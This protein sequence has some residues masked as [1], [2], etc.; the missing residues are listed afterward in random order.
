MRPGSSRT[1]D[2]EKESNKPEAPE[3]GRRNK[4]KTQRSQSESDYGHRKHKN[5]KRPTW[6][7]SGAVLEEHK[8]IKGYSVGSRK[9]EK[10]AAK[11]HME[12]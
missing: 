6:G 5:R 11:D 1:S 4:V 2:T 8:N 3:R 9:R 12:R 7:S 10:G